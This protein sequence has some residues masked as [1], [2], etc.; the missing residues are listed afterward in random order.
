MILHMSESQ[1]NEFQVEEHVAALCLSTWS[2]SSTHT[3]HVIS[4]QQRGS[5]HTPQDSEID[6]QLLNH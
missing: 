6:I 2:S 1:L 5:A 4:A 3:A